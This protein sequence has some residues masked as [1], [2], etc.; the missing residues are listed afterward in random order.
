MMLAAASVGP[1]D[2]VSNISKWLAVVGLRD[3]PSWLVNKT[4]DHQVVVWSF[5]LCVIYAAS[6]WG[7]P[8]LIGAPR[9]SVTWHTQ[10]GALQAPTPDAVAPLP[11]D[12][13]ANIEVLFGESGSFMTVKGSLYSTDRTYNLKI[14]NISNTNDVSNLKVTLIECKCDENS[15]HGNWTIVDNITLAAGDYRFV[16]FVTYHEAND[17]AG[18]ST[19][20]YDRS[21][22][23][24]R[25]LG[26]ERCPRPSRDDGVHVLT[27]RV[28]GLNA[29]PCDRQ[30]QVWVEKISGRLRV[31]Q[32]E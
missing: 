24:F 5:V 8:R 13:R 2:A 18:Y 31:A 7:L 25:V 15:V 28:T 10:R 17:A 27:L 19:N 4:A 30:C 11:H 6:V 9:R 14:K 3:L 23:F 22:T 1:H 12:K 16:P 29:T 26:G 20:R 32:M 21:D